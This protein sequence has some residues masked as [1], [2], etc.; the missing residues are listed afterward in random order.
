MKKNTCICIHTTNFHM[1]WYQHAETHDRGRRRASMHALAETLWNLSVQIVARSLPH[2]PPVASGQAPPTTLA[3]ETPATGE[4]TWPPT[5]VTVTWPPVAVVVEAQLRRFAWRRRL[6]RL[7]AKAP[8][9][10]PPPGLRAVGWFGFPV[11]GQLPDRTAW[12]DHQLVIRHL[13]TARL[14]SSKDSLH[15]WRLGVFNFIFFFAHT[16]MWSQC[17]LRLSPYLRL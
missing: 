1:G 4:A 3:V 14:G 17:L 13:F 16:R 5:T 15:R 7:D 8:G 2:G 10:P 9:A 11:T 12:T 6:R